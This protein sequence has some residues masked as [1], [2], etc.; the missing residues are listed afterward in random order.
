MQ[1]AKAH[2]A[3]FT[4][5]EGVSCVQVSDHDRGISPGS[6]AML[7]AGIASGKSEP[8]IYLGSFA[9]YLDDEDDE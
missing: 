9:Q 3:E 4:H 1:A 7:R 6:L 2:F 5:F 8:S